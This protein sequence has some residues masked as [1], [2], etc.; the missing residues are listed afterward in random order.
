ML[1]A[2]IAA[3]AVL[4]ALAPL[5]VRWL[6]ARSFFVLMLGPLAAAVWLTSLAPTVVAGGEYLESYQWIPLLGVDLTLRIGLLQWVLAMIVTWIGALVLLYSR[7]YFDGMTVA[8]SAA[9]LTI[10]AGTMLGLVTADNLVVLYI[11]WELTTIFSYLLI[12]HDPTRRANRGAA[13]TALIVTTTGGL[14]MLV[15]IVALWQTSGTLSHAGDPGGAADGHAGHRRRAADAGGRAQQ[16][17]PRPVP[18]LA[19]RR[20]GRADAHLGLPARRRHGEGR[21]L[22]GGRPRPRLRV[23]AVVAA[24]DHAAGHHHHDPGRL[25]RPPPDGPQAPP[26]LRHG[27][28]ARIPGAAGGARHRGG[29]PRRARDGHRARPVQV[30][31]LHVRGHHRPLRRHPRPPRA[32]RRGVPGA[33]AGRP[34]RVGRAVH[35]GG[36]TAGGVRRQG[37]RLRVHRIPR[38]RGRGGCDPAGRGRPGRRAG[39]RLSAHRGVLAAL[40]VGGVRVQGRRP[41]AVLA[42]ARRRDRRG[43]DVPGPAVPDRRVPR[44]PADRSA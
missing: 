25:A 2:L 28:P 12:A 9:I 26:R 13:Q 29:R 17:R 23:G 16:V 27:E 30:H 19:A 8:R 41:G 18:L 40:V 44:P 38:L 20:D 10:F 3:H 6:G 1:L 32:Q 35:G 11:F 15:G 22:P 36:A 37:G 14:A 24:D 7:W 39:L 31:P 33:V 34:R 4:G 42:P 5:F 43:A 21:R